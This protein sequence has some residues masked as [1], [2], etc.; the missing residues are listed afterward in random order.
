MIFSLEICLSALHHG[1]Q[2]SKLFSTNVTQLS[3]YY[4]LSDPMKVNQSW[5]ISEK[6][7][8]ICFCSWLDLQTLRVLRMVVRQPRKSFESPYIIVKLLQGCSLYIFSC[9]S[10]IK[11]WA[12]VCP[13]LMADADSP[14]QSCLYSPHS[15][16]ESPTDFCRTQGIPG[17]FSRLHYN[18]SN[19]E[20][21]EKNSVKSSGILRTGTEFGRISAK[22]EYS[23][24]SC[25]LVWSY[26]E[27]LEFLSIDRFDQSKLRFI[28]YMGWCYYIVF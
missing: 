12:S 28:I 23:Q 2:P 3:V 10:G 16:S 20:L 1:P 26:S 19:F 9:I 21:E 4:N 7:I 17:D 27:H 14:L 13:L 15:T 22:L 8:E 11:W 5:R 25:D 18:F 24:R 6:Y